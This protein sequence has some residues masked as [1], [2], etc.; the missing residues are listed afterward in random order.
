MIPFGS[1]GINLVA[2]RDHV[3][4]SAVD[5]LNDNDIVPWAQSSYLVR[6]AKSVHQLSDFK[7]EE[8]IIEI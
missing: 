6:D 8:D 2:C 3:L 7:A 1:S 5:S 4:F